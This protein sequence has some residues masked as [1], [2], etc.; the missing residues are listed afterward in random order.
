MLGISDQQLRGWQRQGLV[1]AAEAFTFSDI[2]AIRTLQKLRENGVPSRQIGR[3][4]NSLR[5]KLSGVRYP[6]AELKI[7]S[8]GRAIS[9]HMPGEK[10]DAL[11]GQLLFDFDAS[12][13]GTL[14]TIRTL[15]A[16]QADPRVLAAEAEAW[17]QRGLALE[18]TGA[19]VREAIEAYKRAIELNPQ[20]AGA[21]LNLGTIHYKLRCF[22]EAEDYY[23]RA[24]EIDPRYALAHFNLGNLYDELGNAA[25]AEQHYER[26]LEINPHYA[27]AHFNIALLCEKR[28]DPLRAVR[29]WKAYLKLDTTTAWADIARRQLA[30]L[31]DAALVRR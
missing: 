11:S 17:F 15:E 23:R 19:P 6:L 10:M 25:L 8:D 3:A 26:A 24:V 18:E 5:D 31:R 22:K 9:V 2:I 14:K 4:L 30:R 7:V 1:P 12:E 16:K 21:L 29:H 13:I 27:D 28:G 20:A